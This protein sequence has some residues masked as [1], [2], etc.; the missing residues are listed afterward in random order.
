MI[1]KEVL[2]E[3]K[4]RLVQAY[5]PV[6]IYLFGSYAWGVPTEDSDLD[7][8]VVVDESEEKSTNDQLLDIRRYLVGLVFQKI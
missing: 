5:N 7:L 3:V 1:S 2:E 4:N 8:L 6:A